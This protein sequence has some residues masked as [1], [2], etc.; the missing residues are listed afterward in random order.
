MAIPDNS[1]I[2][3]K[4]I[5]VQDFFCGESSCAPWGRGGGVAT[6]WQLQVLFGSTRLRLG[7]R[8]GKLRPNENLW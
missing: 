2:W 8:C 6:L 7:L 1:C 4:E 3:P 5:D